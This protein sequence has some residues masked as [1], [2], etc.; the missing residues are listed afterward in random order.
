VLALFLLVV[1]AI[2]SVLAWQ[3]ISGK[4]HL[5]GANAAEASPIDPFQPTT[6]PSIIDSSLIP[7]TMTSS[8]PS[9]SES[10]T[11]SFFPSPRREPSITAST[12][13]SSLPSSTA[14]APQ[15]FT[16]LPRQLF[17]A[18]ASVSPSVPSSRTARLCN[19][20]GS[21]IATDESM[22]YH[23]RHRSHNAHGIERSMVFRLALLPLVH[24]LES[25]LDAG[26]RAATRLVRVW[27]LQWI[28]SSGS[29]RC[30]RRGRGE[31]LHSCRLM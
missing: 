21:N 20:L 22:R 2:A 12:S 9:S 17:L 23:A 31:L 7:S 28:F 15:S 10:P 8:M 18:S 27:I 4:Q 5:Y 19:V 24:A 29:T 14:T 11:M 16:N 30:S 25:S 6:M 1:A 13:S 26:S 3:V